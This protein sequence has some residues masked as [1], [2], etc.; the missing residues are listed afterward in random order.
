MRRNFMKRTVSTPVGITIGTSLS[1][2]S[3]VGGVAILA[4]LIGTERI[5]EGTTRTGCM[6]IH[7]LS[8]FLGSLVSAAITKQKR[9]PVCIITAAAYLGIMLAMT[10]LLFGGQYQGI[11][12]TALIVMAG[13]G[14]AVLP[15]FIRKGSGGRMKKLRSIR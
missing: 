15:A 14:A 2:I 6:F 3:A 8:A 7:F 4:S 5:A 12:S 1:V 11:G 10:A 13:G 9:L